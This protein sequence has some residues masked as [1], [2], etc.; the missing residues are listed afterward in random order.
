MVFYLQIYFD[1]KLIKPYFGFRHVLED[2]LLAFEHIHA[3]GRV[4]VDIKRAN[5]LLCN[6]EQV[7][8]EKNNKQNAR[9]HNKLSKREHFKLTDFGLSFDPA[10]V[11]F[12]NLEFNNI[13]KSIKNINTKNSN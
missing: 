11:Y 5:I 12:Y 4:F 10:T 8:G 7:S 3:N 9:F 1:K 13:P 2:L 6:G